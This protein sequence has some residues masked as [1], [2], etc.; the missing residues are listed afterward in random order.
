MLLLYACVRK[1]K[2]RKKANDKTHDFKAIYDIVHRFLSVL[3]ARR[4]GCSIWFQFLFYLVFHLLVFCHRTIMF[5][6]LLFYIFFSMQERWKSFLLFM[7]VFVRSF[8]MICRSNK[9]SKKKYLWAVKQVMFNRKNNQKSFDLF[10]ELEKI[11]YF[12]FVYWEQCGAFHLFGQIANEN[13]VVTRFHIK[14]SFH[15]IFFSFVFVFHCWLLMVFTRRLSLSSK[16]F[17]ISFA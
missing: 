7:I 8:P 17:I 15:S 9:T 3:T 16:S 2:W 13:S 10:P 12:F 11:R 4:F 14:N 1:M 6:T 5:F